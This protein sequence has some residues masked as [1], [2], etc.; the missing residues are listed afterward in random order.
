MSKP[1]R[2]RRYSYS[3]FK[4]SRNP[5]N[6]TLRGEELTQKS[7]Q[8]RFSHDF[9]FSYFWNLFLS[10]NVNTWTILSPI[11]LLYKNL[12]DWN[13]IQSLWSRIIRGP[14]NFTYIYFFCWFEWDEMIDFTDYIPW[15][16]IF[17]VI[18]A[19]LK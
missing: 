19:D 17:V 4:T 7:N 2:H 16:S 1:A 9:F 13:E 5:L 12:F 6:N 10:S 3:I 18:T 11:G 14:T 15:R 8:I